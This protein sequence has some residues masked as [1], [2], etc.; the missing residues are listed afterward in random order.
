M[1]QAEE[2]KQYQR[3]C[4]RRA[5]GGERGGRYGM[6]MPACRQCVLIYKHF[7]GAAMADFRSF[8]GAVMAKL[9]CNGSING[10]TIAPLCEEQKPAHCEESICLRTARSSSGMFSMSPVA[11][12]KSVTAGM[13][14]VVKWTHVYAIIMNWQSRR[15]INPPCPGMKD[16]GKRRGDKVSICD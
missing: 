11:R 4:Q 2:P 9:M 13:I 5:R 3:P 14:K 6:P 15:S 8:N 12:S 10:S 16:P 7:T 1:Q